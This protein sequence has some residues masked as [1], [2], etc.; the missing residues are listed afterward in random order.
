ML[1]F[2]FRVSLYYWCWLRVYLLLTL[3]GASDLFLLI[4]D[5]NRE[6]SAAVREWVRL[7]NAWHS[8]LVISRPQVQGFFCGGFVTLTAGCSVVLMR[9]SFVSVA[10]VSGDSGRFLTVA[11]LPRSLVKPRRVFFSGFELRAWA[12]L[13]GCDLYPRYSHHYCG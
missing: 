6:I 11:S 2:L 5:T 1:S 7:T 8:G 13:A 9:G 3:R 4:T 12:S 10:I